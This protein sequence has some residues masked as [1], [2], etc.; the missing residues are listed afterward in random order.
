[1]AEVLVCQL[2]L[3]SRS[4]RLSQKSMDG[5]G[6]KA[7]A[8]QSLP[9]IMSLHALSNENERIPKVNLLKGK[10]LLHLF[11][12]SGCD[13]ACCAAGLFISML[14][15]GGQALATESS[16]AGSAAEAH[17]KMGF[18]SLRAEDY[19]GA[20]KFFEKAIKENPRYAEA[21]FHQ[22]Y[23]YDRLGWYQEAVTAYSRAIEINPGGFGAYDNWCWAYARLDRWTEAVATC[24]QAVRMRPTPE[25]FN[26]L[27]RAYGKLGLWPKAIEAFRDAVAIRPDFP[28]ALNNLGWAYTGLDRYAEAIDAYRRAIC[29]KPTLV[30]TYYNLAKAY[31]GLARTQEMKMS[32]SRNALESSVPQAERKTDS[33]NDN[34]GYYEKAKQ[35]YLESVRA[36][37]DCAKAYNELGWVY[38]RLGQWKE[39]EEAYAFSIWQ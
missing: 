14:L 11:V 38:G 22:G 23:S 4:K 13:S 18:R 37:P 28:E 20:L 33:V 34:H 7:W 12:G 31:V 25:A 5:S 15:L 19:P 26:S 8:A 27:G 17:F 9:Q 10:I 24:S 36:K 6:W 39:A 29:L 21:Y 3:L 2:A 35:A 30:E 1:M 16:P 32:L